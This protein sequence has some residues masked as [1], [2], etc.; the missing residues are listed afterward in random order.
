MKDLI[1]VTN[2]TSYMLM[3]TINHMTEKGLSS[4]LKGYSVSYYRL[5]SSGPHP[6]VY[7]LWKRSI[8]DTLDCPE[9]VKPIHEHKNESK[10]YDSRAMKTEI[11]NKILKLGIVK[12]CH[13]NFLIK[14]LLG[15]QSTASDDSQSNI[16]CRLNIAIES[17]EDIVVDLRRNNGR[18]PKFEELWQVK[19]ILRYF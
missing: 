14:Y 13:T 1:Q 6:A 12:P 2:R 17:G 3:A 4:K 10:T 16:F 9:Q 7:F 11:R 5:T 19:V 8:N 15:D 18:Q